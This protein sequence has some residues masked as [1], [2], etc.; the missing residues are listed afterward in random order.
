MHLSVAPTQGALCFFEQI[1][2]RYHF[3]PIKRHYQ[4]QHAEPGCERHG[5]CIVPHVHKTCYAG[6]CSCKMLIEPDMGCRIY[7]NVI[8][9]FSLHATAAHELFVTQLVVTN[10]MTSAISA[11]E[12]SIV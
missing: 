12:A 3:E 1:L 2:N 6:K 4:H 7:T 5:Y 10:N 8:A 9:P 11:L